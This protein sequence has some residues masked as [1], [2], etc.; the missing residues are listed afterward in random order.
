[1]TGKILWRATRAYSL[2]ASIV[3]VTLGTA[4]AARGYAGLGGGHFDAATFGVT[5]LGAMLAHVGAN[6]INDYFD[7][8]KGVDTRPEHGSGVLTRGE[9]TPPQTLTFAAVLFALAGACAVI[10]LRRNASVVLPLAALGLACAVIY[11]AFLKRYGLGDIL[12][13][14]AFGLGLTLGSYGVQAGSMTLRQWL[15]VSVYSVPVCLLVDAILHANNLRDAP[16]D[17]AAHVRTLATA[18]GPKRGGLLQT[19]LLFGPLLFVVIGVATR[20]LPFWTLAT[21]LSLPL[22]VRAYR[23]GSVPGTAQ[24]HLVFGL[25]YAVS[26]LPP[27][28]FA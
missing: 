26:F 11:P 4:L 6:V 7:F 9:M 12:I 2:P 5:L 18:L 17:R 3:P 28:L 16:D 14:V 24:T 1:M 13:I 10:L 22:L 8:I 23:S 25:L 27:P 21:I 19:V 15:L 20:L